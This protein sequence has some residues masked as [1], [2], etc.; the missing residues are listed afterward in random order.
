MPVGNIYPGQVKPTAVFIDFD[1]TITEQDLLDRIAQTFGDPEVYREVDER[2]DDKTITLHEVLRREFEPVRAPLPQVVEWALERATIRPGFGELVARARDRD[3]RIIVLS[4][5]FRELI[6][7]LL[8]REGLGDL[9]LVSNAVQPDPR[10]WRVRFRDE[11]PCR[12]CGEPCE[13]AAVLAEADGRHS[14]YVGDGVSDRCGAR[15]CDL[16]FA[17]RGL[18]AYLG[19]EGVP[20]EPFDDFFQVADGIAR[21]FG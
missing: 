9:K 12:V 4:S 11:E 16:V 13:S 14:V 20:F 1:G 6:E 5:G 3:W 7:P 17:R 21:R 8:E 15:A 10:G 19:S 2:L 18:A